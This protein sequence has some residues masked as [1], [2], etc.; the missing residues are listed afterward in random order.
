MPS[1]KLLI[2]LFHS[3]R[4]Y[5]P[6]KSIWRPFRFSDNKVQQSALCQWWSN[7]WVTCNL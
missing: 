5:S 3:C 2:Q 6:K 7:N 1:S 4:S